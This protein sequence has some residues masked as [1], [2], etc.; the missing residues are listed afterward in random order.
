[1]TANDE[2]EMQSQKVQSGWQDSIPSE[3]PSSRE[4][5][6]S[7]KGNIGNYIWSHPDRIRKSAKSQFSNIRWEIHRMD[8]ARGSNDKRISLEFE[9]ERVPNS[10]LVF[11]ES[12]DTVIRMK[13]SRSAIISHQEWEKLGCETDNHILLVVPGVQATDHQTRALGDQRQT[14]VVGNPGTQLLPDGFNR[15]RKD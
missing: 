11:W 2:R 3:T 8:F 6:C 5:V 15:S 10:R 9:Q 12:E 1:M 7:E 13:R 14:R 4:Q